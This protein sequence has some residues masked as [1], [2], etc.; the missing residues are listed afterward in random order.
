LLHRDNTLER[1]RYRFASPAASG[2]FVPGIQPSS[3]RLGR[4][5]NDD[6][7]RRAD[8][9][10]VEEGGRR[11]R[12]FDKSKH[13]QVIQA[14]S[15]PAG[16]TCR[17]RHNAVKGTNMS[18]LVSVALAAAAALA[19]V[20]TSTQL[21][22]AEPAVV[23]K[24]TTVSYRDLNLASAEGA[25]ELHN[26]VRAAVGEVCGIASGPDLAERMSIRTCRS[27]ALES[28]RPQMDRVIS[29]YRPQVIVTASR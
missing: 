9:A 10:L 19:A 28:A 6:A 15:S 18:K 27:A 11:G 8:G 20:S 2:F 23:Y 26:R 13:R 14:E 22:A 24:T 1:R 4:W 12:R 16:A 5:S 7:V 17:T 3:C 25:K 29:A 21:F